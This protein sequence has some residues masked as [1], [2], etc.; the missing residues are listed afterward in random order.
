MHH[1]TLR[2]CTIYEENPIWTLH[3]MDPTPLQGSFGPQGRHPGFAPSEAALCSVDLR[4]LFVWGECIP[5]AVLVTAPR[6]FLS[7]AKLR[8]SMAF[9][10]DL[11][12]GFWVF[13]VLPRD[14]RL[15]RLQ[16]SLLNL[17]LVTSLTSIHI[18]LLG[19]SRQPP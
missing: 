10:V 12:E 13:V 16:G 8:V 14:E 18:D 6:D 7:D 17:E 15:R 11:I 3:P 9:A 5:S 2:P 4:L 1:K 19:I